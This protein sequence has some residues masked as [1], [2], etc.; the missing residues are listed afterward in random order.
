MAIY[1]AA[2]E[3]DL[4]D[5]PVYTTRDSEKHLVGDDVKYTCANDTW[6][7][8]TVDS[9]VFSCTGNGEWSPP[10]RPCEGGKHRLTKAFRLFPF[11]FENLCLPKLLWNNS[12]MIIVICSN[13][14]REATPVNKR[15]TGHHKH[16]VW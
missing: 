7:F 3:C 5:L 15:R 11:I 13:T 4:V 16:I 6:F 2:I 14:L 8:P 10:L 1:V 12:F 9:M